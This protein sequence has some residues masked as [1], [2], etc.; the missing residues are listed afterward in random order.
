MKVVFIYVDFMFGAGGKYYEGIASISALLKENGHSVRLFHI[1][2]EKTSE[3]FLSIYR[4]EYGDC[5]I[6]AFSATTNAFPFAKRYAQEIKKYFEKTITVCGGKHPTL[7]PD[8]SIEQECFDVIC[9][10]E[11]EH[12]TLDLCDRLEKG[13]DITNIQNL[14]VKQNGQ[15]FK[16]SLRPW[17]ADLDSLPIP[18]K[19]IFDYENSVD[20]ELDRVTFMASRGCPFNCTYC[21]N[22]ALK[23]IN[24]G[25]SISYVRFKSVDRLMAEIKVCFEK[26]GDI[27][28]IHFFDDIL[29]INKKWYSEFHKR[30]TEEI[31]KPYTCNSRF[32]LLNEDMIKSL[33][34]SGCE[35]L[36]LGLE[37]G[38]EYIRKE[39]LKRNQTESQILEGGRLCHE[40]NIKFHLFIIVGIPFENLS[41]ALNTVKLTAEL[42]PDT[43]QISIFCPYENTEL[44]EICKKN[45][46]LG[47]ERLSSYF[48]SEST[49]KLPGFSSEQIQFTFLNFRTF[50]GHYIT[51]RKK[52]KSIARILESI[53]DFLWMHP[54]IYS[55]IDPFYKFLKKAREKLK[56]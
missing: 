39:I 49:L 18:D 21:C 1:K 29:T 37:S 32:D 19:D 11:G 20:K 12:P 28:K 7:C 54:R 53:L 5:D 17:V 26:Y 15:I 52:P 4:D 31:G 35:Q 34:S 44:Y 16:N 45:G 36:C 46:F 6:A 23:K 10:G 13:E 48:E 43:I 8:E 3:D 30:Y 9:I 25:S 22:H 40:N 33:A 55:F 2:E 56:G 38:D 50:V 51:V 47:N 24:D 14:W 27:K 42:N 41:R